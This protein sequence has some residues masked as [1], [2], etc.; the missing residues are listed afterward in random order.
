MNTLASPLTFV[1]TLFATLTA[2]AIELSDEY[3]LRVTPGIVTDYRFAG[4][5]QSMGDPAAQLDLLLHNSKGAYVGIFTSGVDFG[6]DYT[7]NNHYATRQEIDYYAGYYWQITDNI[8][9]DSYYLN[10]TY[11]GESQFNGNYIRSSLDVYGLFVGLRH[12]SG[13]DQTTSTNFI[14]YHTVLPWDI[15]AQAQYEVVDLKDDL[16]FNAD[17]TK[18]KSKYSNWEVS[19]TR[20][21]FGV[22]TSLSYVDTNLSDAEC[23]SITGYQDSCKS[24]MVLGVSKQF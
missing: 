5:S 23:F 13:T 21:F 8:A 20:D 12:S 6:H 11:P 15:T 17:F 2:Q 14:G 18:S 4:I 19:L 16:I 1:L 3:T 9:L 10:Y 7:D 22:T 24:G